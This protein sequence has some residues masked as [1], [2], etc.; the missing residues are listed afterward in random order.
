MGALRTLE[1]PQAGGPPPRGPAGGEGPGRGPGDGAWTLQPAGVVTWLLV[2]VVTILFAS[3]TS[4]YLARRALA[5]WR[6]LAMPPVL[7]VNT[8]VLLASSAAL[9]VAR[10]AAVRGRAGTARRAT[11]AA[12][13]LGTAFLL[14]QM[15]AWRALVAAGVYLATSPHSDFFY[16]L[17]GTHALHLAGGVGALAYAWWRAGQARAQAAV[18]GPVAVYWHFVD[19]LW[20]YLV[21][22]LF[23]V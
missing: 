15:A 13:L 19:A 6:P 9:E 4:T 11:A 12:A 3:F 1:K 22:M 17:T 2:G 18:L 5:D 20:L 8:A 23:W 7:W 14:G 16:L 10:R 21:V